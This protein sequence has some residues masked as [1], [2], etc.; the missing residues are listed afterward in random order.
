MASE[1]ATTAERP[2]RSFARRRSRPP[3]SGYA[4]A[5]GPENSVGYQ[6]GVT[7][8]F[9]RHLDA[10]IEYSLFQRQT[11]DDAVYGVTGNV[12]VRGVP[13]QPSIIGDS[14]QINVG[15]LFDKHT[16]LQTFYQR[17][18]AGSFLQTTA[19]NAGI[20]YYGAFID[21]KF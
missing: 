16:T 6:A 19:H 9:D 7:T 18:F 15:Y 4:A 5:N 13:S 20:S 14:P 3:I 2:L 11:A 10:T 17:Y 8:L 21:F 1:R 12:L